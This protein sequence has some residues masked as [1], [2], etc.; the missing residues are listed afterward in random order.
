MDILRDLDLP[1]RCPD[2]ERC[3]ICTDNFRNYMSCDDP[4][5]SIQGYCAIGPYNEDTGER[6]TDM[7]PG[8]GAEEK[9]PRNLGLRWPFG[10]RP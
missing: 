9:G 10:L 1:K 5:K 4:M 2:P 3:C 6:I 7:P 8:K